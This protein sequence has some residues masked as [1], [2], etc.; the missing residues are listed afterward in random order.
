[1]DRMYIHFG[2][3]QSAPRP[4]NRS[5]E[6]NRRAR[7]RNIFRTGIKCVRATH[8]H[9]FFYIQNICKSVSNQ[10]AIYIEHTRISLIILGS[11]RWSRELNRFCLLRA[12]HNVFA[13]SWSQTCDEGRQRCL[14]YRRI[15]IPSTNIAVSLYIVFYL[16]WL[17]CGPL[18]INQ[19]LYFLR[20]IKDPICCFLPNFSCTDFA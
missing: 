13:A 14:P 6:T 19:F 20:A 2:F 11:R 12:L 10:T 9:P 3:G 16:E 5:P 15:C 18:N 1:M 4:Q 17:A 7:A 8:F